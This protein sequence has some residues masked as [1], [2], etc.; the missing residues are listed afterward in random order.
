M[1]KCLTLHEVQAS[2]LLFSV[3]CTNAKNSS[4]SFA[5]FLG[6]STIT[7]CPQFSKI[8]TW[9]SEIDFARTSA[10]ETSRTWMREK[11]VSTKEKSL[12]VQTKFLLA[13]PWPCLNHLLGIL[14]SK[15]DTKLLWN[16]FV[17]HIRFFRNSSLLS[18]CL[19]WPSCTVYKLCLVV[20]IIRALTTCN[21]IHATGYN[22]GTLC[23]CLCTRMRVSG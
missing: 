5:V 19:R 6:R 16:A 20:G 1:F 13:V 15:W 9:Q 10:P 21:R 8:C 7:E 22:L 3:L 11:V 2:F 18:W 14:T 17:S 12:R 23:A 4:T